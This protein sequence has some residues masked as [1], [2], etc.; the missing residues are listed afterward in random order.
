MIILRV[1][2]RLLQY[3]DEELI[4]E[5]DEMI[6]VIS[7]SAEL[8][9]RDERT[10]LLRLAR[11]LKEGDLIELQERYTEL[12]DRTRSLSLHLFEHVHGESRDRGQAMVDLLARYEEEGLHLAA[13]ELPDYLPLFLEYLSILPSER[14]V[15]DLREP[16]AV[17]LAIRERLEKRE[18][19]YAAVLRALDALAGREPPSAELGELLAEEDDDPNDFRRIDAVYSEEPVSFMETPRQAAI[20]T[21]LA[22][23]AAARARSAAP[24]APPPGGGA[25]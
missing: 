17:I 9:G 24:G 8:L 1:L 19:P 4:G 12:F 16:I 11:A 5:I 23:R 22:Q 25:S 15:A 10:A 14:A 6:E 18:S 3:P 7:K 2:S 20:G 21:K 13:S